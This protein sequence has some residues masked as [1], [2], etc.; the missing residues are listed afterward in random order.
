MTPD[1]LESF[2]R[3]ITDDAHDEA[4]VSSAAKSR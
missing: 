3:G 4:I 1:C 2:V